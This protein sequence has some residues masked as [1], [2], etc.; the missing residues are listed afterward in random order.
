MLATES[1]ATDVSGWRSRY[2]LSCVLGSHGAYP[3]RAS[4]VCAALAPDWRRGF[5][6][7]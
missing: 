3:R 7:R 1:P 5:G 6:R 4:G 2:P